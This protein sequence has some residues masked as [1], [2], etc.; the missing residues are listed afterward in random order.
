MNLLSDC[1]FKC[2]NKYKSGLFMCL[3]RLCSSEKRF[4]FI[5]LIFYI[6]FICWLSLWRRGGVGWGGSGLHISSQ[7][8]HHYFLQFNSPILFFMS[9]SEYIQKQ[10]IIKTCKKVLCLSSSVFIPKRRRSDGRVIKINYGL[11][12]SRDLAFPKKFGH[13]QMITPQCS[14]EERQFSEVMPLTSA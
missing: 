10:Q 13:L 11:R 2:R 1:S 12:K 3:C 5:S 7:A 14:H 6:C 8:K 4:G 9:S